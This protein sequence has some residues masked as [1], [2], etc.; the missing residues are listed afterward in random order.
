MYD[1][2]S[3]CTSMKT[4]EPQIIAIAIALAI[5]IAIAI[6]IVLAVAIM[7]DLYKVSTYD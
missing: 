3:Y 2:Y 7:F 6:A 4:L 1:I 5:A